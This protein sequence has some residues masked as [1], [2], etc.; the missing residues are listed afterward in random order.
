MSGSGGG[1]AWSP[2]DEE[3]LRQV[4]DGTAAGVGVMD[5]ELR[6]VYVNPALGVMNGL[7]PDAHIGRTI[8]ELLPDLDDPG[9]SLIRQVLADGHPREL[10]SSGHTRAASGLERRYWHG[11]YHRLEAADGTPVGIVAIVLEVSASRAEQ[12]D[13]ERAR[14]RLTLLDRAA[15]AIG[16]TL[17]MDATCGE[18]AD[19]VVP[20]LADIATVEVLP[21]EHPHGAALR[22]PPHGVLR[23]RRAALAALP[24]L[25]EQVRVFGVPGT[26][27]DYQ[28][29]STIPRCLESGKP[30]LENLPGDDEL[31][32]IAPNSERVA[33][34]RAV[35]IHSALV[36]PLAARGHP[37]GTV[38]LVR[39]G[40]S[41]GFTDEDMVVAQDLATRAAISLDNARRYTREHGIALELQRALLSEPGS[42]HPTVEVAFRYQPAGSSVLVG[43][44]WY[45]TVRLPLGRTLLA[46]GDVMGHG[47][48]AS[49]DMSQYRSML[50]FVAS[51]D[52]P[53]HR[54]LR[55]LDTLI[56][57]TESG[58]PAT[59]LLALV[60]PARGRCSFASAGHLPPAVLH[61]DGTT[62]II[63]LP[64][65]PPLGTGHGGYE[66]LTRECAADHV[67][68]LYTDGLIERRGEDIDTSL[69]RL[70]SLRLNTGGGIGP[71]VDK[72]LS[73]LAT[74][75][76]EDDIAVLAARI[77]R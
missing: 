58:R 69:A 41:P 51:A 50:R 71:L 15:T 3:V 67:L 10:T 47:V 42:P 6:Y 44:D 39:A 35:G 32:R 22:P 5:T 54:I 61:A 24:N 29:G 33:A 55:R 14:E 56:A 62:E 20:L 34:Y 63:Q 11:A 16:T 68:L 77:L 57:E 72:V 36:V 21:P 75:D 74:Q 26:Y 1:G 12:R 30:I 48:E 49:V 64:V 2:L 76:A 46:M 52:L 25:R 53:P 59:C 18:L 17:E 66:L 19:F 37:V 13:L 23:L 31:G 65:G 70:A 60:D 8:A 73:L 27:V 7:P 9:D 43:G 4:L 40:D 38:T 45:D 28:P